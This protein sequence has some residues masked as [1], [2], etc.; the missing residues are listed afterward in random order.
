MQT[1]HAPSAEAY[2]TA[3]ATHP[4]LLVDYYKDQ[5]PGCTMLE[6]SLR[7]FGQQPEAAGLVLLKARLEDLGEAFFRELGLRQTPTLALFEAGVEQARL[8]GFQSPAQ[9][10]EAVQ[11]HLAAAAACTPS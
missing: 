4:R 2:H 8:S 1:L 10:A 5:C 9:L 6:L 3:L 11:R 7:R